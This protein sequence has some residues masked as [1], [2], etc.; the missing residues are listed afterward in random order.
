MSE[1]KN[2]NNDR[3]LGFAFDADRQTIPINYL[4]D[5][6]GHYG[7]LV[8]LVRQKMADITGEDGNGVHV[9][10]LI[11]PVRDEIASMLDSHGLMAD[12]RKDE[13]AI[14]KAPPSREGEYYESFY[15]A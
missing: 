14:V 15:S 5:N 9:S 1:S 8:N 6:G 3:Q 10:K 7:Y 2:G 13:V 12:F 4:F 11:R